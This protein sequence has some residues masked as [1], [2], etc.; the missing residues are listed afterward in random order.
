MKRRDFIRDASGFLVASPALASEIAIGADSAEAG[1]AATEISD[2]PNGT[3]DGERLS[4]VAFP[5]GGI[6]AGMICME[7]AGALTS[8]SLHHHPDLLNEPCVFAAVSIQKPNRIA[9]VLEGPV[10]RWKMLVW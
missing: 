4:R 10:P 3:Y 8:F 9:R 6:G 1:R 2:G 5:M 7:G